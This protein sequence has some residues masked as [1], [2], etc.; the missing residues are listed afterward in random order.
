MVS[1]EKYHEGV[2]KSLGLV[3][4]DI[5]TSPIYTF[6][7]I[8]L[9]LGADAATPGNIIGVLSLIFWTLVILVTVEYVWLAMSLSKKGE[10]G[11]I[12]LRELLL[13]LIKSG[14]KASFVTLISY[15]G[16]SLLMGDGVITPAISI[17]S[18]VEGL[19][20]VPGFENTNH[21]ALVFAAATIAFALFAYQK[22]GTEKVAWTFGPIMLLWFIALAVS[23]IISIS[24]FPGIFA[25]LWPGYG[26]SFIL[27]HGITG[28]FILSEVI[29]CATGGEAL[30]ADMGHLGG[31]PIIRAWNFVF[32]ALLLNYFGQ[33][34]FL[35]Q[36]PETKNVLFGMVFSQSEM[37]YMPFLLLSIAATI[38][39]SQ[40]MISGVFSV[41]Y[42]GIATRILPLLKIDYTSSR[43][44]AQIYI[45]SVNWL[46]LA[47]VILIMIIFQS[48]ENLAAAYGIAVTGSMTITAFT[49]LWIFYYKRNKPKMITAAFVTFIAVLF[50]IA[51]ISKIPHGGYVSLIIAAVPLSIIFIY[52]EGQ[53]RLYAALKPTPLSE[54]V[55][56]YEESY[57]RTPKVSG[58]ALYFVRDLNKVPSYVEQTMF[59]NS[60]LYEDNVIVSIVTRDQPFGVNGFFKDELAEGL[61]SF[62]IGVGYMEI[63]D[64]PGILRRAG[65]GDKTIF[66]GVEDIT[67]K[68]IV[69]KIFALIKKLTQS[70]TKF[71]ELD[72]EKLY[73]VN[74][75]VEM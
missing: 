74:I 45:E 64:V 33:G 68:S 10:G 69:W 48:S 9:T 62:E 12:V 30:Y 56:K 15:L 40:A 63:P 2:I 72:D 17:L 70:F 59:K 50:A 66:Y 44:R 53:K 39:A 29:L 28:F 1:K 55:K 24:T 27:S 21:L 71:Y 23:G 11:T 67:S 26:I 18:A 6:T 41:V 57:P 7:V 47:A 14:R 34:A 38:I 42:Q 36:H 13:P 4:G 52:T 35:L 32:L 20:L 65:I 73:S 49:M 58:T 51:N 22:K 8:M 75:K 16:V 31:K 54:F 46:M 43:N 3:F 5:G 61:R 19:M 60:M 37:L 25:A